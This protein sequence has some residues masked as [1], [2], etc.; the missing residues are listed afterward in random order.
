MLENINAPGFETL[1]A[2][3]VTVCEN[4]TALV[5]SGIQPVVAEIGVGIGA[6]TRELA[7][8]LDNRG[9]L[10]LYD[11]E[12][13]IAELISD[14]HGLGYDNVIGFGNTRRHWD[15]Y[16][17]SLLKQIQ[18]TGGEIYDYI[19]LDGAHTLLHDGL[20]FFL[21][22]KL[23]KVGGCIDFDDYFW[24][25]SKSKWMADN[26]HE[27]MTE[28]QVEA[29]QIKLIVDTLVLPDARYEEVTPHKVYRKLA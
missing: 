25:V 11:F 19:Y 27:F 2:A 21:A 3:D 28:E 4:V 13:K 8:I 15:S 24:S 6:T 17:W 9:A 18:D 22:D 5:E 20:A 16:N 23:L 29:Q 1:S 7:R 14:I 10:H 12:G 26:R